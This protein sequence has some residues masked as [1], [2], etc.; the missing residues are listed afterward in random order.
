M[1]GEI[2]FLKAANFSYVTVK[3]LILLYLCL[4]DFVTNLSLAF[5]IEVSVTCSQF[6]I[7]LLPVKIEMVRIEDTVYN[8]P[9]VSFFNK[10]YVQVWNPCV[11]QKKTMVGKAVRSHLSWK[12]FKKRKQKDRFFSP[13][14]RKC[15]GSAVSASFF[16]SRGT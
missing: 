6:R 14:K 15:F 9:M 13:C 5:K 7:N 16:F 8:L 12:T 10:M 11:I 3:L 4:D 1:Q 2:Y